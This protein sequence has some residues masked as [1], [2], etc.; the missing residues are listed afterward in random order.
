MSWRPAR[1][2]H[3]YTVILRLSDGSL[4]RFRVT[5][6]HAVIAGIQTQFAATVQVIANS[7]NGSSRPA[8]VRLKGT[9]LRAAPAE[10]ILRF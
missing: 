3:S 8:S 4:Q 7:A 9:A 6:P 10:T 1:L 2:A 5:A